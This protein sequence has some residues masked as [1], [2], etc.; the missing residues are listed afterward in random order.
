MNNIRL[1]SSILWS[2]PLS[3]FFCGYTELAFAAE[4]YVNANGSDSGNGTKSSPWRTLQKA[5]SSIPADRGHTVNV[6]AGQYDLG[7]KVP[8]PSG[9]NLVGSGVG[10]TTIMGELQVVKVKDVTISGIKFDGKNRQYKLGM[11]IRDANE[12]NIRDSAFHGYS[13]EAM[14]IERVSNGEISNINITDSSFN[15]R[16]EGGGGTQS[17]SI[18]MGNLSNFNFRNLKIDTR[19]RGGAGITSISD[20][21]P[22]DKPWTGAHSVLNNVKFENLDIKVDKWN[23]WANGW[24]PQMALELWHQKCIN[25]EISNSTFNSTVSLVT[26]GSTRIYVH[27][28]KWEGNGNPYYAVEVDSDNIELAN[29]YI[30]GGTYPFAMFGKGKVRN[31]LYVHHNFIEKTGEPVLVANYLGKLNNFR[32]VNNTVYVDASGSLF[33]L[34]GGEASNQQIRNN[35]FYSANQRNNGFG[36]KV[37]VDQNLFHNLS[38]VGSSAVTVDPQFSR[39]GNSPSS[40]YAPTNGTAKNFGATSANNSASN[41]Q[42]SNNLEANQSQPYSSYNSQSSANKKYNS[43]TVPEPLTIF[44]SATALCFGVC[45]MRRFRKKHK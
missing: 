33:N 22:K 45:M 3:F 27:N 12:L 19:V 24:T 18:A 2:L 16:I 6:G 30:V 15:N 17:P 8:V 9:L 25:C 20:A 13:H 36:A 7:G 1:R 35:I 39:S 31:N 5:F 44:G 41:Q 4:Y 38:P 42:I 28:N 11:F 10:S 21:W 26:D 14:N 34:E 37:G 40:Y 43:Q 32:F 23:A 29:N